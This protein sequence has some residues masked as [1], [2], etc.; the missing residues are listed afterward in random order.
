MTE[1]AR[2]WVKPWRAC[3]CAYTHTHTHSRAAY[4]SDGEAGRREWMTSAQGDDKTQR[5]QPSHWAHIVRQWTLASIQDTRFSQQSFIKRFYFLRKLQE[6]LPFF[7]SALNWDSHKYLRQII[8]QPLKTANN[9]PTQ[10]VT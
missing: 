7:P 5:E 2:L 1:C 10:L 4:V 3:A 8:I 9:L 6:E